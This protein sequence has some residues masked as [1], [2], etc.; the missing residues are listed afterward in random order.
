MSAPTK[1]G[2]GSTSLNTPKVYHLTITP[3]LVRPG[4]DLA[5]NRIAN[6]I[7][8]HVH[9]SLRQFID[10][11]ITTG[12]Q[13]ALRTQVDSI[14]HRA[15]TNGLLYS[16]SGCTIENRLNGELR[17][18]YVLQPIVPSANIHQQMILRGP[19]V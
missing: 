18:N 5:A 15:V 1:D 9:D 16:A 13:N 2:P 6:E 11:P 14:L 19:E 4:L 17:I 8:R 3:N 10:Q 12:L 7:Q